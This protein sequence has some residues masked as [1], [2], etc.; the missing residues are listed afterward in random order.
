MPRLVV[1]FLLYTMKARYMSKEQKKRRANLLYQLRQKGI[2]CAIRCYTI[3]YPYG[4]DPDEITEIRN[5][6]CEF[7]FTVQFEIPQA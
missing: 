3:F 5:L 1:T 2:R 6:R 7:N 4:K